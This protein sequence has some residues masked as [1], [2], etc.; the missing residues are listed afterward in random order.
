M[1]TPNFFSKHFSGLLLIPKIWLLFVFF[2]LWVVALPQDTHIRFNR[3]TIND[4]LSLSSVYCIFQDSKGFMWFGTEDGLNKYDGNNFTIFRADPY[5]ENSISHKWTEIVFEDQS[6][7]LWLGSRG[8]LTRF[9]PATEVFGQY[10]FDGFNPSSLAN[11]TVTAIAQ[12]ADNQLWIGTVEG[13]NRIDLTTGTIER[14]NPGENMLPGLSTRI[15]FL[16]P[17]AMGNLWIACNGGLFFYDPEKDCFAEIPFSR[18]IS[19]N[20]LSFDRQHELLWIGTDNGLYKYDIIHKQMQHFPVK[21][22]KGAVLSNQLIERL[23]T[24]QFDQIWLGT[25]VG[26]YRFHPQDSSFILFVEA[27]DISNS[28]SINTS[29]PLCEDGGGLIWYGT[30]GSGLYKI[31]PINGRTTNYR[32]NTSDPHSLSEN[33]INCICPDQAGTLWFGTFGAGISLF[34]QRAHKFALI[35]HDPL[36]DNSLSGNFIW[37][38]FEAK[39]STVWIGTNNTGLNSYS[40]QTGIFTSYDHIDGNPGSLSFSSVREVYQ[41]SK[42]TIWVG[43][44]GGGLD[45]FDPRTGTFIH[46]RSNP[47]GPTTISNNS[48][49]VVYEDHT[50]TYWVGTR[51]G[52]NKFDPQT[53]KF[54]RFL[55]EPGNPNSISHNFI[56]SALYRDKKGNLWIGTYGGG[57]NKMDVKN[58]KFVSYLHQA[59]NRESLSDNIV[60][61][62]FEGENGIFW[63]GTNSGLNRFDPETEKF[64]HFGTDDG[65]PNEVVY[66]ILSDAENN[67]WLST[68]LG[69]SKFNLSDYSTRNFDVSD[70]LQSNEFNGGAFHKGHSGKFY[71]GGVYGLN[72]IS[73]GKS[74]IDFNPSDV[75]ITKLDIL[76]KEVRVAGQGLQDDDRIQQ[77]KVVDV[78]EDFFIARDVSY[79]RKIVL[80][81]KHRFIGFEFA[82]LNSPPSEKICYLYKMENMDE[83]WNNAGSRNYVTYANMKPGNYIFKVDAKNKSGI[84]A[85]SMAQLKIIINPPFWLTWWFVLLEL[86]ALVILA[87]FI[88][89]YLLKAKTNRILKRQNQVIQAANEQLTESEQKL[90]ELNATKDK[91][92]SIVAHDLKNPFTSLLS[93]S[94]LLSES[95]D[96]LD[97]EDKITGI[98]S[99]HRSA[100]RIYVLLENLLMWSRSQTNRIKYLPSEFDM[101]Q[102]ANENIQL[103]SLHAEKKELVLAFIS[104]KSLIV[105]ADREMINTML[106]NFLHNAIK[107]SEAGGEVV[108]ELKQEKG[109]IKVIVKDAGVG[110]DTEKVENL[111]N[112]ASKWT[113]P[114][115]DGEKGTGLGLVVCKEFIERHGGKI[116]VESEPGK[117]SVFSFSLPCPNP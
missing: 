52:L 35:T 93:I 57:L 10:V 97:E 92:F 74:A 83:V 15:N 47:D 109:R 72:V 11:D 85:Q 94:E 69:V 16:L 6:G 64:T 21:D 5:D 90:K 108:L 30:F 73:P 117:G 68:N 48:V 2:N 89:V 99:F 60:F 77:N 18:D 50:G 96:D 9:D 51:E 26:L 110:M 13:L 80:E 14:I 32:N 101:Y 65:L 103:F 116:H 61:S 8:G 86:M 55:H 106:R 75:V 37:S 34:D 12:G 20:I 40:P 22:G 39:D 70:G 3:I 62:I 91:F 33:S 81:Y 95:Y 71:F 100:K 49:R 23:L 67:I 17:D 25:P 113:T 56:Y 104:D 43:T 54:K 114:G 105:F 87:V 42:G 76:G 36:N 115:T 98:K 46:Y 102:L 45:R 79:T 59:D 63:I 27:F 111:F 24:D 29:K 44:D 19:V 7:I 31:D 82:A 4:G 78:G 66:G 1:K 88:Y 112:L 84:S 107:Y 28:L 41:D 53:G 38:V 58:E